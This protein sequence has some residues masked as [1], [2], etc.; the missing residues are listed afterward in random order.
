M[1]KV[2]LALGTAIMLSGGLVAQN[3]PTTCGTD[4]FYKRALEANPSL[5]QNQVNFENTVAAYNANNPAGEKAVRIIPVVFH[6]IHEGG[7]ENISKAQIEDQIRILNEDF[8]RQNADTSETPNPFKTVAADCNIEFRLANTDPQGNCTDGIVRIFSPKTNNASDD[9]GIKAI[10]YWP[11]N[12]YLNVWVVKSID[13]GGANGLILGYAQLPYFGGASTDGVVIRHDYIG[14]IGTAVAPAGGSNG[15]GRTA[16]H[17]VG[18]WLG[19]RHIWGDMTCGSDGVSDTPVHETANSG[20]PAFPKTN[21]CSGAGPNGEMFTNYMDYTNGSCQNMFSLGQKGIMDATLSSITVRANVISANNLNATGVNNNPPNVCSPV[22]DFNADEFMICQGSSVSFTDGTWNATPTQWSWSF[23][24]G[25]PS[26]SSAQNPTV[27]YNTPGVYDATLTV[28]NAQGQNSKTKAAI[29]RVSATTAESI[30][31]LFYEA[32]ND[33]DYYNNSWVVLNPG[34]GNFGWQ[35]GPGGSGIDGSYA[36]K[37]NAFGNANGDEDELISPS[38]KLNSIPNPVLK[39]KVASARSSSSS[40]DVLKVFFSTDCGKTW[41][42]R[43]SKAG[44]ALATAGTVGT[45]FTP[46]NNSQYREETV[47]IP[48]TIA[49]KPNVRV[50]FQFTSIDGNNLYLDDINIMSPTGIDQAISDNLNLT[51]YPNPSADDVMINFNLINKAR[52]DLRLFDVVGKEVAVVFNGNLPSGQ[53]QFTV[54]KAQVPAAGVYILQLMVDG[55]RYT[56]RIVFT[57]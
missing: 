5:I 42:V 40:A 49:N 8:R 14:S 57:E 21:T 2:F 26:T 4:L 24:G 6:V 38:F 19:L 54:S 33:Q 25:T 35:F 39:F 45:A 12:K 3:A 47:T 17:E 37:M 7:P 44:A 55:N 46:N 29:V 10:S 34:G 30:N 1:K 28:T 20:C 56:K 48:S 27:T 22:A 43:Y 52:T 36:A 13:D 50:K 18:H 9:N 32:F 41:T 53:N 31:W 15:M 23:P 16:T 51:A 11:R